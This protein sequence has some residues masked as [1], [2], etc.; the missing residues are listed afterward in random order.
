MDQ[1]L[2]CTNCEESFKAGAWYGCQEN[3]TRKHVVK[4]KTYYSESD[5]YCV[6]AI[7]ETY[8]LGN[9]GDRIH[10]PG[11]IVTFNGGTYSTTD[12]QLQEIL[13]REAPMTKER[14]VELRMT[15]ELKAGRDRNII[16]EQQALIDDL[17]RKNAELEQKASATHQEEKPEPVMAASAGG[18]RRKAH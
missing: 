14:Y 4:S 3:P 6:N 8:V 2:H 10:V 18:G 15:P 9:H 7:P 12:P 11:A 13:D 5:R 1:T 16:S 17:K